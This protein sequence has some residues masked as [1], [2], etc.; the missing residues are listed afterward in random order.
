M[1][2]SQKSDI[3]AKEIVIHEPN[4]ECL[5]VIVRCDHELKENG[6]SV[7]NVCDI[8]FEAK[9]NVSGEKAF[10]CQLCEKAFETRSKWLKRRNRSHMG[11]KIYFCEICRKHFSL[12]ILIPLTD[13]FFVNVPQFPFELFC[14]KKDGTS[15]P[16]HY[17]SAFH[18]RGY[19]GIPHSLWH[20]PIMTSY[21][22]FALRLTER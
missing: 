15:L 6:E 5:L 8:G 12:K 7:E 13:L 14:T 4:M 2:A 3:C 1:P 11:Y 20:G 22:F 17:H 16:H 10:N 21:T 19:K 9:A 18:V